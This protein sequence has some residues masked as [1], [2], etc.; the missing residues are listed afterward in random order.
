MTQNP[1]LPTLPSQIL[2]PEEHMQ[3]IYVQAVHKALQSDHPSADVGTLP[4]EKL[5]RRFSLHGP[6]SVF[7]HPDDLMMLFR[8]V[9]YAVYST[10]Y[11]L[12]CSHLGRSMHMVWQLLDAMAAQAQVPPPSYE[13][14]WAVCSAFEEQRNELLTV[15]LQR[16]SQAWWLDRLELD[17]TL[18]VS[19]QEET[20]MAAP[21]LWYVMDFSRGQIF[22]IS[23]ASRETGD[24][25]GAVVLYEAFMTQRRPQGHAPFGLTWHLPE[26]L[27]LSHA[28]SKAS[29][30]ACSLLGITVEHLSQQDPPAIA[31]TLRENWATSIAGRVLPMRQCLLLF[32]AYLAK[33]VPPAPLRL[34]EELQRQYGRL[35]S[36]QRD[37]AWLFPLLRAFLPLRQG[38][39][40]QDGTLLFRGLHYYHPFLTYWPGRTVHFR[41]SPL[42]DVLVWVYLEREILCQAFAR[43]RHH[44]EE[45]YHAL[46]PER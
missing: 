6:E 40:S 17:C 10:A 1:L 22:A 45:Q 20:S 15:T 9:T 16:E 38:A 44:Q 2:L 13:A 42:S 4:L 29:Q 33:I 28:L 37:G 39:I 21:Y 18:Q 23:I 31:D 27:I 11:E 41:F 34:Q 8:G 12:Y 3:H 26:R 36:Y 30:S 19:E 32:D 25:Q 5:R 14:I 7:L 35:L 24:E 43:Q 46:H